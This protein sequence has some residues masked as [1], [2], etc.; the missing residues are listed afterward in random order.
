MVGLKSAQAAEPYQM[1]QVKGWGG[2]AA[3]QHLVGLT[4]RGA[5]RVKE[6]SGEEE[7]AA[8]RVVVG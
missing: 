8:R 4:N 6:I 7:Q 1:L 3:R 2:L 5:R